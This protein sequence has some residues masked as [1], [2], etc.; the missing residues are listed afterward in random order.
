MQVRTGSSLH[1]AN[2][3]LVGIRNI[4]I[5]PNYNSET[6]DY[7]IALIHLNTS[8]DFDATQRPIALPAQHEP[9]ADGTNC[10]V[11]GWGITK[12]SNESN[13]QLR[14][15]IVPIVNQAECSWANRDVLDVTEQMICAGFITG[16]KDSMYRVYEI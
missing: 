14:E 9:I 6:E 16:G 3:S 15:I 11:T 1:N 13:E 10:S 4:I 7:D 8:L 2:G 5:H 12:N